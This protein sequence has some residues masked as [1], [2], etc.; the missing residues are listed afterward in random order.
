MQAVVSA[1]EVIIFRAFLDLPRQWHTCYE[2]ACLL[3][4]S[5]RTVRLKVSQL[6]DDKLIDEVWIY[7]KH[8]YRLASGW[9]QRDDQ[10]AKM[11]RQ[12][13]EIIK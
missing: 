3:T 10:K 5:A 11:L 1:N 12:A 2:L 9:E 6:R 13:L 8:H 7:P 4:M